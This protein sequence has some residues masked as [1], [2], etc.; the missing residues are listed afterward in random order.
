MQQEITASIDLLDEQGRIRQPGWA[1]RML[2][3]YQRACVKAHPFRI[4]EWDFYEIRNEHFELVLVAYDVG[5]QGKIQA[6]FLDY[7]HNMGAEACEIKW[8]SRG[9]MGLPPTSEAGNVSIYIKN[10]T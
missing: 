8:F 9:Q 3:N 1:K 2:W 4:K 6:T 7:D 10:A 5:Y